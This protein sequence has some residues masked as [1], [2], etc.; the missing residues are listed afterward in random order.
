M[1]EPYGRLD[2][3]EIQTRFLLK[4]CPGPIMRF[5]WAQRVT[6]PLSIL[7]DLGRSHSKTLVS[8]NLDFP[9]EAS[10]SVRR[11]DVT[12]KEPFSFPSLKKLKIKGSRNRSIWPL[13]ETSHLINGSPN[14]ERL[15]IY[16]F[17]KFLTGSL[18][19]GPEDPEDFGVETNQ[20]A[21]EKLLIQPLRQLKLKELTLSEIPLSQTVATKF[22]SMSDLESITLHYCWNARDFLPYLR[23]GR[24]KSCTLNF[25]YKEKEVYDHFLTRL[26]PGL[27]SLTYI[28]DRVPRELD[29]FN[30]HGLP[31]DH[32][33]LQNLSS[34]L[35]ILN[36]LAEEKRIPVPY[37]PK[38]KYLRHPDF[39]MTVE[40]GGGN[41]PAFDLFR[42]LNSVSETTVS[43]PL[44]LPEIF[45]LSRR[46]QPS[47][48]TKVSYNASLL[49]W[50]SC[51]KNLKSLIV[52]PC[53]SDI[54]DSITF[55]T[56]TSNRDLELPQQEADK[57]GVLRSFI[58][59]LVIAY[60]GLY[61]RSHATMPR[62]RW[63]LFG[64][65][66]DY[67]E[68]YRVE[69]TSVEASID[70]VQPTKWVPKATYLGE[71]DTA[72]KDENI[73]IRSRNMSNTGYLDW[74]I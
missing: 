42:T 34:R 72:L 19:S 38:Y 62:L 39:D 47:G 32:R 18:Y 53:D 5:K 59:D 57:I 41:C 35:E 63:V 37:A 52:V 64:F 45:N 51:F 16:L 31:F 17:R 68:C 69:W 60:G 21:M 46:H 24:L 61:S 43:L 4:A 14:L 7:D 33:I 73:H 71:A 56:R 54:R 26:N 2:S 48:S 1:G 67:Q 8:L 29:P 12:A 11:Y 58:E 15:D 20:E 27:L 36:I 25:C 30:D 10:A 3:T 65:R 66:R 28:L 22:L 23:T 70:G 74:Y 50:V 6:P 55:I 13:L 49:E 40:G 9:P 44:A